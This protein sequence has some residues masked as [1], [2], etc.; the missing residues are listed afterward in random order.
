MQASKPN[1]QNTSTRRTG[2]L[3][4][5]ERPATP[6]IA[7]VDG[8]LSVRRALARLVRSCGYGAEAFA[9]GREYFAAPHPNGVSCLIVDLSLEDMSGAELYARVARAGSAPP[10]IAIDAQDDACRCA[11][12]VASFRK[13]FDATA[14]IDAVDRALDNRAPAAR[15][16]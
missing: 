6:T 12:A 14:L 8:D 5:V 7:I 3:R 15:H 1:D 2:E 13:P 10:A 4:V 16:R 11:W 9:T